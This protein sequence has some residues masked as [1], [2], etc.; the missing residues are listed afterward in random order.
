MLKPCC[1]KGHC[2]LWLASWNTWG[3]VHSAYLFLLWWLWKY[4]HMIL[5]SSSNRK[6]DPFA[7]VYGYA[8]KHWHTLYV[9]LYSYN[10]K[11][12]GGYC[13]DFYMR[14]NISLLLL[15]QAVALMTYQVISL[16][17]GKKNHLCHVTGSLEKLPNCRGRTFSNMNRDYIKKMRYEF[18]DILLKYIDR[19][20][21]YY[22]S[23][24]MSVSLWHR[25]WWSS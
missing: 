23:K 5:L 18:N 8:M 9:F 20:P 10:S 13:F 15:K 24:F 17:H 1:F 22:H 3:C 21:S 2:D 14:P 25:E 4:L 7:I 6:Y 16:S 19:N 12:M 11:Y